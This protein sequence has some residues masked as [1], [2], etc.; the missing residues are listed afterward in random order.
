MSEP[1]ERIVSR[2]VVRWGADATFAPQRGAARWS[3][4]DES[5]PGAVHTGFGICE[6]PTGGAVPAHV[7]SYEE[8]VFVLAGSMVL[9]VGGSS[10]LLGEGDYGMV[11]T[12]VPHAIRNVGL[13]TARWADMLAPQP[14]AR[15]GDDTLA[16][17]PL[18]ELP[19]VPVDPRDPRT[20]SFGHISPQHMDAARQSQELL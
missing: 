2:H 11:P 12:G 19:P 16:V 4:V 9:D 3:I 18:P 17:P 1:R 8:S 10:V 15:L 6:L 14:R 7:H 20:R 13:D 5:V